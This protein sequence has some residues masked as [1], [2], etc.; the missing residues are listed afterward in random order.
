ML[1]TR[2]LGDCP[3]CGGKQR[4][5]N[6]SVLRDHVTRGCLSC[7][8]STEVWLPRVRKRILYLDQFFFSSAFRERDAR[9]VEAAA[10]IRHISRLQLLVAP[11]SSIHEDETHQWRGCDG[12]TKDALMEFIK[13][14]SGGH[15]FER[16]YNVERTQ[17]ERAFQAFLAGEPSTFTLRE[18]DA[19][20]GNIHE[21]EDYFRIDV[22]G[23]FGNIEFF[24]EGKRR[25]V[26]GLVGLFPDWRRSTDS[27]DQ[28]VAVEIHDAAECYDV[29]SGLYS[30]S[31]E[32]PPEDRMRRIRDFFKSQYFSD[33]PHQ[34]LSARLFA[35]LRDMVKG[36]AYPKPDDAMQRLSGFFED[37]KHISIYAPYC[38]AIVMDK[39]MAS[40][41]ANP[42]VDLENR[43]GVKVF[44]VNNWEQLL[45]WLE[46]L[47]SGMSPLHRAGLAAAYP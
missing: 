8:Y 34:W 6:V 16:A 27:F 25:S 1:V 7:N 4:F 32:L 12:K 14:T 26:D 33:I 42:R 2:V 17:I 13:A 45:A 47:E 5:G 40:L 15:E 28:H 3:S 10:R 46:A 30:L 29:Q 19:F 41:V 18:G 38:D 24:R 9:F 20:Y 44:S 22:D 23:Y 37:V 39:A 11:F 43:Y 36:G 35:T 21:W 31:D